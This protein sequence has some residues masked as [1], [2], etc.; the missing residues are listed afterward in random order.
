MHGVEL[1]DDNAAAWRKN[2]IPEVGLSAYV[3]PIKYKNNSISKMS[4]M[5]ASYILKKAARMKENKEKTQKQLKAKLKSNKCNENKENEEN[6]ENENSDASKM[7]I[8]N[9]SASTVEDMSF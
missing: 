6:E 8:C 4:A 1:N 7:Y 5:N 9:S 3:K 2:K